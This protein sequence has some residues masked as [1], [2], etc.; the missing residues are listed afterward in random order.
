MRVCVYM[1]NFGFVISGFG[2]GHVLNMPPGNPPIPP[3]APPPAC[4]GSGCRVQGSGSRVQ[5][6]GCRVQGAAQSLQ[7]K[8][9][10]PLHSTPEAPDLAARKPV[11]VENDAGERLHGVRPRR[12]RLRI[13]KKGFS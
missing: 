1:Y 9:L 3:I 2:F 12:E 4:H 5:G 10:T 7:K 8:P 13:E 6:P 11:F